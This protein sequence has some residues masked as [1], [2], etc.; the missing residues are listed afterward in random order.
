MC[1]TKLYKI[2]YIFKDKRG[3]FMPY[4]CTCEP[5]YTPFFAKRKT[6]S[7]SGVFLRQ[8]LFLLQANKMLAETVVLRHLHDSP[9]RSVAFDT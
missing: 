7:F 4:I 5:V 1:A 8:C 3:L 6:Q 2:I 9:A